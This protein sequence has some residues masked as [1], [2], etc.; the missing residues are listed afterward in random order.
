MNH[1][2]YWRWRSCIYRRKCAC[3]RRQFAQSHRS[4]TLIFEVCWFKKLQKQLKTCNGKQKAAFNCKIWD[5]IAGV[6]LQ[7]H[8]VKIKK[9]KKKRNALNKLR[10]RKCFTNIISKNSSL[11]IRRTKMCK[12]QSN[13]S[14]NNFF[15]HTHQI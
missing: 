2:R 12:G 13:S 6:V 8:I 7:D 3:F 1:L 5:S 14:L 10:W 4:I 11:I 9:K 15:A